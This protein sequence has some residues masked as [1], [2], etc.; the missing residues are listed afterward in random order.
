MTLKK[1]IMEY[2]YYGSRPC[3]KIDV[4]SER[5]MHLTLQVNWSNVD[6]DT[7]VEALSPWS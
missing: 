7:I 6:L 1:V 4:C 2:E 3:M 5:Q